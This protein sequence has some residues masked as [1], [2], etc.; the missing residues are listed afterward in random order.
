M[1]MKKYQYYKRALLFPSFLLSALCFGQL[2]TQDFN[3]SADLSTYINATPTNGQFNSI[4]TSGPGTIV[5]I[6]ANQLRFS[7]TGNAGSFSRTTDF[8][9]TPTSLIYKFDITVSGNSASVTNAAEWEVGS[10]FMTN[11]NAENNVNVHSKIGLNIGASPGQ[12][13]IRNIGVSNSVSFSGQQTITWYINNSGAT[14]NYT[15]PDAS[16]Q[17]VSNDTFDIWVGNALVFDDL[18][19]TSDNV[20]LTDLKFVFTGGSAILD[21]DNINANPFPATEP[22]IYTGGISTLSGFKYNEGAGPST[23]QYF[24]LSATNLAPT[25]GLVTATPPAAYEISTDNIVYTS[26]PVSVAYSSGTVPQNPVTK[27]Y[28]RLKAGL[29]ANLYNNQNVALSGGS[30]PVVNV[31][32]NGTVQKP[33]IVLGN[34]SA[35]GMN[36]PLGS[37][38]SPSANATVSGSNLNGNVTVVPNDPGKWEI[39]TDNSV[40]SNSVTYIP[41]GG[42]LLS[43][44]NKIYIRL[45]AGLDLGTYNGN[46]T[47]TS[48][49]ADDKGISFS[50]EV[51][52]PVVTINQSPQDIIL[53]GFSY[54]QAQG[55]SGTQNFRVD[56]SN[57]SGNI[58]ATASEFWEIST[59]STYD[60]TANNPPY[61]NVIFTKSLANEV[62]NKTVHVRLK[63]GLPQGNYTGTIMLESPMAQ[64]RIVS[65]YGTVAAPQVDMKVFGGTV[66]IADGST[67]PNFLNRT[68]FSPQNI[69]DSQIK[70]YTI[71]NKGGSPLILGD[72]IING[73]SS[74]DFSINNQPPF[75]SQLLQGETASFEIR[76][77]PSSV[78]LKTATIEIGNNDPDNNPYDFMVRGNSLFCGATGTLI[79]AQQGFEENPEFT[80][81]TYAV[82]NTMMYGPQTGFSTGKSGSGDKP[83]ENNLFGESARGYRIQGG[84][85]PNPTLTPLVFEFNE[86][87]TSIYSNIELSFKIA[88]FSL[89]GANNGMDNFDTIG[90]VTTNHENKMDF[91]LVEVS[92]D[93]GITWYKQAKIVSGEAN[94]TWGFNTSSA[95]I[96]ERNYIA[97]NSLTYFNSTTNLPYNK[98]VIQNIPEVS[99]LKI[100]ISTQDNVDKES[101]ILDDIRLQSTG[102]VPKV[103]NGTAWLPSEP[104]KSDKIIINGNYNTGSAGSLKVCQCEINSGILT[105][106]QNTHV[107]ISDRLIN[108]GHIVV[109]ND[110]SLVQVHE[111]DSNSGTGTFTVHRNANLK[112]LDY[113]YW[114]SPVRGQKLKDFSPGTVNSRFYTYNEG[115]NLFEQIDPVINIFGNNGNNVFES[116][117]KGYAIRANNSYPPAEPPESAPLQL[118]KGIFIG[119]PHNAAITFPL[120]YKSQ[121]NG[122]GYNLIGNPY[123][124]NIDFYRLADNNK[125]QIN[126]TAYFWTNMNPNPAMQGSSYPDGGYYNNYA[127]LNATGGIPATLGTNANI[128]SATPNRIIKVGQGFLVKA[129]QSGTLTFNNATRTE[130][131]TPVF[132][133]RRESE[134]NELPADR[135]WLHLSTPLQVVTTTL[136]GYLD[137]ATNGYDE[138]FDAVLFGLGADALFTTFNNQLFGIQGRQVPFQ[139][140]D[141]VALGTNHYAAGTYTFSLGVR[142][143]VFASGQQ[144]YLKDS[145]TGTLTNLSQENYSFT[146]A[147]GL[148]E[149]RFEI[150]YDGIFLGNGTENSSNLVVYREGNDFVLKSSTN[151][152]KVEIYDV[153]GR[154]LL[155][156]QPN[157]KEILLDGS[158]WATGI[159]IIKLTRYGEII[160]R[161]IRK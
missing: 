24:N 143:G 111:E 103:W 81:L 20:N 76:F 45:K 108:N 2:F 12:F 101:W 3:S 141:V 99:N 94:A 149:G 61:N 130:K 136:I 84:D 9:P 116:G 48:P 6:N 17:N 112:R 50:G 152:E 122:E 66:T 64:N 150:K 41:A 148:T 147:K 95:I 55:P 1:M 10:G 74:M 92:P 54:P 93:G 159:Y 129:K 34:L 156:R 157:Q 154:L 27:I 131:M 100:R 37:G 138:D 97:N 22:T 106:A 102:I 31:T 137:E 11:N 98:V 75:G 23:S 91:V 80:E 104:I 73:A 134:N 139:Q 16:S 133:N 18:P 160:S 68:M 32:C 96:G 85:E 90:S 29:P 15:A 36:Y 86:I 71:T 140:T 155:Q 107:I 7:R 79:I 123:A 47:A 19:A 151:I 158:T 46:V 52:Q 132:F 72:F 161:K 13:S 153:A 87:N 109:E 120:Q 53:T 144:I 38:P 60:G 14:L 59:N 145:H 56:G 43:S 58:T 28:V 57:L 63:A 62:T 51:L 4:S 88:A 135:F 25:S 114:A 67:S 69:G 115:T 21:I 42:I 142:E 33:T 26:S 118:F 119:V 44:A 78:G 35:T 30:A 121:P 8:S 105:I 70:N 5:S 83:K 82:S 40:W 146:A 110:A 89:G 113:N 49:N 65:L 39:S 127:L 77:A 124:S 117:A 125:A 128:A 126:K